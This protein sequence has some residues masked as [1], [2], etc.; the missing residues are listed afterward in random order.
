MRRLVLAAALLAPVA[1]Q[2]HPHVMIDAHA[3]A[4]FEHGKVV[5]LLVG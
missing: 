2:A 1:A 5:A 4:Q 3:V